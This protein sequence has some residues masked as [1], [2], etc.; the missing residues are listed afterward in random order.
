LESISL[1]AVNASD[2]RTDFL[3]NYPNKVDSVF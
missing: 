1:K 3:V 2:F